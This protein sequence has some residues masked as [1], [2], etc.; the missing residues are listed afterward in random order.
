M[1]APPL[2][3]AREVTVRFSGLVAVDAVE[4]GAHPGYKGRTGVYELMA[5]DAA[6][7]ALIHN[8]AAES[9]LADAA[10]RAGLRSMREDGER[11][12]ADGTTSLEELVRVTREAELG[13]PA[14]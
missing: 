12:L 10:R 14:R 11:L 4:H 2:L 6:V 5:A 8:R 1:T 7:Q 3:E 13:A 9:A